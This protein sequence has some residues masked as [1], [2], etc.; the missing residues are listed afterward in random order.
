MWNLLGVR[1]RDERGG[2]EHGMRNVEKKKYDDV[3]ET[4]EEVEW[5]RRGGQRDTDADPAKDNARIRPSI[6]QRDK[7]IF[8]S[9]WVSLISSGIFEAG[10]RRFV[11][12]IGSLWERKKLN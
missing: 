4:R 9:L 2:A 10:Y 8:F 5:N 11:F 7:G 6:T 1:G 12:E 3:G